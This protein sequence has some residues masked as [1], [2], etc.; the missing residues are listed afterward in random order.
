MIG[1]GLRGPK[2]GGTK[3]CTI[4]D[5]NANLRSQVEGL[6]AEE[7]L[8]AWRFHDELLGEPRKLTNEDLGLKSDEVIIQEREDRVKAAYQEQ[9]RLEKIEEEKRRAE[10]KV[11]KELEEKAR[12]KRDNQ[13]KARKWI[14]SKFSKFQ[15]MFQV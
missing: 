12:I 10:E 5:F 15:V 2:N 14:E 13:E 7:K 6:S 9:I 4:V 1:R 11:R 8:E 3:E